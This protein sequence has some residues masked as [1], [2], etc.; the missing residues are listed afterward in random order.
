MKKLALSLLFIG[1]SL[2]IFAQSVEKIKEKNV[3]RIIKTLTADDMEGRATFSTGIDKAASF[4]ESEF[5]K[6]G[7]QTLEGETA[8]RQSFSMNRI[9]PGTATV[10]LNG[11]TLPADQVFISSDQKDLSWTEASGIENIQLAAGATF[12][13]RYREILRA[14]KSVV[15]WVDRQYADAFKRLRDASFR[16]RMAEKP[17]ATSVV[18]I[19]SDQVASSYSI[20]AS[21]TIDQAPLFNVAGVIP[22]KSKAKEY[23]VFSAHYDHLGIVKAVEGDSIANGADDDASGT[24]AVIELAKYYKKPYSHK[25][26]GLRSVETNTPS[27]NQLYIF[28]NCELLL[29]IKWNGAQLKADALL[30]KVAIGGFNTVNDLLTDF[31]QR[32]P[33]GWVT[34]VVSVTK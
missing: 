29:T 23:V 13:N 17:K 30:L 24:T 14:N 31:E 1:T 19:L 11:T 7:L 12:V 15:V 18:F 32:V 25:L 3:S 16:T 27:I 5:K 33:S 2:T 10:S 28:A 26:V 8:F 34:T 21:N 6:I 4:I 20:T 9:K 22:G